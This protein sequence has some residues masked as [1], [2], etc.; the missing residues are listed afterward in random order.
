MKRRRRAKMG[1]GPIYFLKEGIKNIFLNGFMSFAAV[2]IITICLL[3]VGCFT[4]T[5][6]NAK[7]QIQKEV[8]KSEV[9]IFIEEEYLMYT[10]LD[11]VEVLGTVEDEESEDAEETDSL[12]SATQED[13]E[14]AE[15]MNSEQIAFVN[16][17]L[18]SEKSS[19]DY[20]D[21]ELQILKISDVSDVTFVSKEEALANYKETLG[22]EGFILEG[23]EDDNPLRDGYTVHLGSIAFVDDVT[24]ALN[25][26]EGISYV[27]SRNETYQALFN[28]EKG[29]NVVAAVSLAAFGCISIF[30]ISNTVK[31]AMFA[32]RE[33]ISIMKM[34]G[35]KDA[36]IKWPFIIEG[37]VLG[38][39]AA[40]AAF[41]IT[42]LLYIETI[43]FASDFIGFVDIVQFELILEYVLY[44][45]LGVG[46][47]I[48]IF[49]SLFTIRKFLNV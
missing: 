1:G 22:E 44:S 29:F 39:V 8:E 26:I 32:R 14:I 47:V 16:S 41:G 40:G 49:G 37:L 25:E 19:E 23:F 34:I 6:Y 20:I 13:V 9:Q 28:I 46:S 31:L 7:I 24:D 42:W 33:E 48:G 18:N 12:E 10:I 45:Y 43:E 30:I 11:Y 35:A 17:F 27:S 15:S 3:V 2:S 4:L 5:A 21:I 36:F 38:L